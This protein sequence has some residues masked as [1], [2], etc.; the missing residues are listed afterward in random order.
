[1]ASVVTCA[2]PRAYG[3]GGAPPSAQ[4]AVSLTRALALEKK[5]GGDL[6]LFPMDLRLGKG[7]KILMGTSRSVAVTGIAPTLGEA[8][9]I[10]LSGV[11]ALGRKFRHRDDVGSAVDIARSMEHLKALRAT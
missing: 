4:E 8:H 7:G 2:V 1:M 11:S 3:T 5:S 9:E 6:R 10:S